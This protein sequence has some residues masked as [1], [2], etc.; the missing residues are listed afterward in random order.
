MVAWWFNFFKRIISRAIFDAFI[1]INPSTFRKRTL[2][3]ERKIVA[4][5]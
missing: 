5:V 2:G 3:F 4:H 1:G